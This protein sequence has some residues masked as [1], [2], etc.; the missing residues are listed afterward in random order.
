MSTHP[1]NPFAS[2]LAAAQQDKIERR[3]R[4]DSQAKGKRAER[5]LAA[6]WREHGFPDASRA[7]KTGDRLQP[8]GGDL[9]LRHGDFRLVVE[10]KHHAGDLTDLQVAQFCAKLVSQVAQSNGTMGVLVERR[11]GVAD[12]GRWWAHVN[13]HDFA[14]LTLALPLVGTRRFVPVRCSVGYLAEMLQAMLGKEQ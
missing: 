5:Q 9:V 1:G 7:V 4:I 6:W 14:C 12:P 13:A 11:D 3:H 10:V 2:T 8:D